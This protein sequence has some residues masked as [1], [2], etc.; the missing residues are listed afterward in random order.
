MS[1]NPNNPNASNTPIGTEHNIIIVNEN[2]GHGGPPANNYMAPNGTSR[3]LVCNIDTPSYSTKGFGTKA[4]VWAGVLC[5]F[6]GCCCWI[7]FVIDDCK[8][9]QILCSKCNNKKANIG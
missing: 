7:P 6:T 3:C 2:G 8:E 1:N 5:L 9:T 4:Y